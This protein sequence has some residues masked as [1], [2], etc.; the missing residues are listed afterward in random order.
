MLSSL[1]LAQL[2]LPPGL[3]QGVKETLT[4]AQKLSFLVVFIGGVL[5]VLSPCILPTLPAFFAFTFKE[6]KNLTK[7]TFIFFLGFALVF[8]LL[9][10][11]S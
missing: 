4:N 7:M 3:Q 8:V 5:S 10:L 6:K 11:I 1:V 2:E 9:G